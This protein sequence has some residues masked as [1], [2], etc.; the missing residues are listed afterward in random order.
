M[1]PITV[2]ESYSDAWPG[3]SICLQTPWEDDHGD[4]PHNLFHFHVWRWSWWI[5]IPQIIKPK[6]KWVDLAYAEWASVGKDGRKGY[7]ERIRKSYGF[8]FT[9]E[10]VHVSYGIQPGGWS[11]NDPENSD[12]TKVFNYPF[13]LDFVR[14]DVM[15]LNQNIIMSG[16]EWQK[17]DRPKYDLPYQEAFHFIPD[18]RAIALFMFHDKFNNCDVLAKAHVEEREWHRGKWKW[19][20]AI[21]RQFAWGRYVKRSLSVDFSEEVGKRKGSWKGGVLGTSINFLDKESV[22]DCIERFKVEFTS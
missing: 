11:R 14:W 21:T 2:K 19:L 17:V 1:Q 10:S 13:N 6:E 16:D 22:Y 15:D 5:K 9:P 20:K 7:N 12:H 4:M 3:F 8:T 18:K